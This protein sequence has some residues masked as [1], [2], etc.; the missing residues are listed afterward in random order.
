[1]V[2]KIHNLSYNSANI[3]VEKWRVDK[4]NDLSLAIL[5]LNLGFSFQFVSYFL[6]ENKI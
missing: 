1:M 6:E 5:A 3:S 4:P 2:M